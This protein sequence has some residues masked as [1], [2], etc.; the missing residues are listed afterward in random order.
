MGDTLRSKWLKATRSF[1][2]S[3]AVGPGFEPGVTFRPHTLSKRAL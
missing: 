3:V 2:R 1:T